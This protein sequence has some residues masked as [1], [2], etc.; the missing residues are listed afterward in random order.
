MSQ[1]DLFLQ[2]LRHD[3][4]SDRVCSEFSRLYNMYT[5]ITETTFNWNDF[6]PLSCS[7]YVCYSGIDEGALSVGR[8]HLNELV[9]IKL[10]GGLGTSMGCQF[11]KSLIQLTDSQT[12]LDRVTQ[13]LG[14]DIPLVLMNS[15]YTD[16]ATQNACLNGANIELFLQHRFPRIDQ[17]TGRPHDTW[18]PPGHG[19]FYLSL[20]TSGVLDRLLSSGKRMAFVS[21]IDNLGATVDLSILG[22]FVLTNAEFL[23]EVTPKTRLD[24]K[25][26]T[27]AWHH[28]QLTLLE[29]A[30]VAPCHMTE[31][32]DISKFSIFNT[33]SLWID[34]QAIRDK[35]T[36]YLLKLPL[37]VNNKMVDG[38]AVIQLE[39][40]MGAA[41]SHFDRSSILSVDRSRFL[42]VKRTSDLL[43]MRSDL[44][45]V[46][47]EGRYQLDK[48]RSYEALPVITWDDQYQ[49]IAFFNQRFK[50]VPS[51]KRCRSL[52]IRGEFTFGPN[53][54]LEGD[55]V[56]ESDTPVYL[57]QYRIY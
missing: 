52:T 32:E 11:P 21:N 34:L 44:F 4:A 9:V 47:G 28:G 45:S 38:R 24:V 51:M 18:S 1:L 15:F 2:K 12:F 19:N 13:Q 42:P 57:E 35:I 43:L 5:A 30:Q 40:A 29:R 31:F 22:H 6:L 50:N 55:V 17:E 37:I 8:A 36:Q 26:G 16:K 7:D 41:I 53:V 10:N 46:D 23:M 25:G 54:V 20:Y 27:V 33:N 39:T 3:M 14:P 56:L 49:S 48:S